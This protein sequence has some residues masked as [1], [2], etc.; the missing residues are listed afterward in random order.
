[1]T[2][3][4]KESAEVKIARGLIFHRDHI[5]LVK[6]ARQG[7]FFLP[8]GKV[9]PGESVVTALMREFKEELAWEIEPEQFVGCYE[10]QFI[11]TKKSGNRVDTLEVNFLWTCRRIDAELSLEN[12]K[13]MEK[14][15]SFHWEPI[16]NLGSLN[17]LPTELKEILPQLQREFEQKKIRTFWG[18]SM[19]SQSA[20]DK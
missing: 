9:D 15:I 19:K 16:K 11:Y 17:F 12:P 1:M 20:R 13:S 5:L 2:E 7:H 3:N 10:H 4:K 18:S 6:S 14:K 8:G